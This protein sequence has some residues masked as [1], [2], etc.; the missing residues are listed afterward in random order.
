MTCT[1]GNTETRQACSTMHGAALNTL[2]FFFFFG[3]C[4]HK[5]TDRYTYAHTHTHTNVQATTS[6]TTIV[7]LLIKGKS[8][9]K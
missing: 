1:L 5:Y 7:T 2:T 3:I 8:R 9:E 4:M 6:K